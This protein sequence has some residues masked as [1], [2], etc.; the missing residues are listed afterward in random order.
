MGKRERVI[1]PSHLCRLSC[2]ERECGDG[3]GWRKGER[4]EKKLSPL[5][6][7]VSLQLFLQWC[8]GSKD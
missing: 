1:S 6:I 2:L 4:G 3:I 8:L 7:L 5:Y